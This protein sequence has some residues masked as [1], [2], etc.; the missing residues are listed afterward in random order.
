MSLNNQY[1]LD[2]FEG[3]YAIFLKRPAETEQLI[4]H[5]SV[6]Q[7]S[8]KQGDIVTIQDHG[9]NYTIQ[10]LQDE[11]TAQKSK[12]QNLMEQLRNKK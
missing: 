5:R 1:T 12:I 4:I 10:V 2:R 8:V 3:E 7:V 6:I 9:T 11:T